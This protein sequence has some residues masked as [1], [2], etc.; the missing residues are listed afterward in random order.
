MAP[1]ARACDDADRTVIDEGM[2]M[3]IVYADVRLSN[4]GRP[5]LE[6]MTVTAV[7]DSGAMDLVVPEHVAV[8]LQ[9]RDLRSREVTLADGSRRML[10]YVGPIMVQA[11]GRDCV[12]GAL[13]MGDQVLLGAIPLEAMDMIV[14]PR[15]QRL[16]PNPE[17]PNVPGAMVKG[18][19][20]HAVRYARFLRDAGEAGRQMQ[21]TGQCHRADDVHPSLHARVAGVEAAPPNAVAR[22]K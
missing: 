14:H 8:Q 16:M 2:T 3:A 11:Q 20:V 21:A 15:E 17:N 7:V 1:R 18:A 10:R 12:T 9:L 22:R 5:D 19:K 4:F 13:V 6:E